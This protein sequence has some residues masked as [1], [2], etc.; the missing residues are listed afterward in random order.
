MSAT[1]D[2]LEGAETLYDFGVLL[3]E[4]DDELAET[5]H[6]R[7]TRKELELRRT[8]DPDAELEAELRHLHDA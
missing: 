6:E 7:L 4:L 5:Y 1:L 8:R 2:A 3:D